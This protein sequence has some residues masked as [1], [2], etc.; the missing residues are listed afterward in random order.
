M[1]PAVSGRRIALR[2]RGG[3][4]IELGA[5]LRERLESGSTS[6]SSGQHGS[7]SAGGQAKGSVCVG[8]SGRAG[9]TAF[10][11][12]QRPF[13]GAGRHTFTASEGRWGCTLVG[14]QGT[15]WTSTEP[16]CQRANGDTSC[17]TLDFC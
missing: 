17:S 12:P 5:G 9:D 1:S 4:E 15:A 11:G 10:E 2:N 8:D 7:G 6:T 16:H 13:G 14:L 3:G